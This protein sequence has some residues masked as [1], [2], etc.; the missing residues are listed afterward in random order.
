MLWLQPFSVHPQKTP[1]TE[2]PYIHLVVTIPSLA[3]NANTATRSL[4][5]KPGG[6]G[7]TG[8]GL[9]LNRSAKVSFLGR[10]WLRLRVSPLVFF[11]HE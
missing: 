8:S 6:V 1:D 3:T 9:E 5:M 7:Q 4:G 10:C 2:K 11:A